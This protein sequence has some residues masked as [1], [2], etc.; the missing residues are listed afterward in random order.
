[1]EVKFNLGEERR[2]I[3]VHVYS[4]NYF[5]PEVMTAVF[6]EAIGRYTTVTLRYIGTQNHT[7]LQLTEPVTCRPHHNAPHFYR[8]QCTF[9]SLITLRT[10]HLPSTSN[11]LTLFTRIR[12]RRLLL[13]H[14]RCH[15]VAWRFLFVFTVCPTRYRTRHFFNNS[16]TTQG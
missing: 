1:V 7:R 8:I 12:R 4:R 3:M 14:H 9:E 6:V 5:D 16:N 13:R 11:R 10:K 2:A 15:S